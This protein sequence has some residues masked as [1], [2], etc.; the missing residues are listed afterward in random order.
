MEFEIIEI[1][2]KQGITDSAGKVLIEPVFDWIEIDKDRNC[3]IFT[4]DEKKAIW[5]LN[6][7]IEL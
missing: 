1:S 6:R 5:P 7:L 3:V 2:G 4:L